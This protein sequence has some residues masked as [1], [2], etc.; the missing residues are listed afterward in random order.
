MGQPKVSVIVP[1]YNVEPYLREC[2]DSIVNQSLNEIE[3]I[4]VNDG[5]KDN[6]LAIMQEYAN[7][8]S[9]VKIISKDN[10]GYGH[11]MNVGLDAATGK[12]IGIVEPDDY[13]KLDMYE[14]L[15]NLA[16]KQQVDLI[17]ADAA[18][19]EDKNGKRIY[20]DY[21]LASSPGQ[22]K[23]Y[24]KVLK[25]NDNI[26]VYKLIMNTWMGIYNRDFL[27]KHNIRHNETP[28][29]SFQDNGFWFQTFAWAE[30]VYFLDK[31][32]YMKRRDNPNSSVHDPNKVFCM[33]E[34][35]K[36]IKAFLDNNSHLKDDLKYMYEYKKFHNFL[37]SYKRI[38][39]EHKIVFLKNMSHEFSDDIVEGLVDDKLFSQ[40]DMEVMY[41]I[42]NDPVAYFFERENTVS[43]S[44]N[45]TKETS[46]NQNGNVEQIKRE[47]NDVKKQLNDMKN[48][49]SFKIGR[50][51]TYV[52]RE[53]RHVYR[54][55]QDNGFRYT[56]DKIVST[57]AGTGRKKESAAEP[58]KKT[59]PVCNTLSKPVTAKKK[60]IKDYDYYKNLTEDQYPK[61]L[62]EWYHNK[63]GKYLNL[64]NP[65][66]FNE[67]IQWLK[68][69]DSTPLKTRLA[70][71]YLVRDWVKEK[72]GEEYLIPLLGVYEKFDDI[73]FRDLPNQFVI[74]TN[75]GSGWNMVVK[76]KEDLNY[77][78]TKM[79]FDTWMSK[80]FAFEYGLELHYKNIQ[81][82]IVI[83]KYI[84]E[85]DSD[86]LDYRFFCFN[87]VP[88]YVW[89]DS[90]SGTQDHKR[91][92][93]NMNWEQQNY[94]V[95][96]PLIDTPITKPETFEKMVELAESLSENFCFVRIDFYSVKGKIFFGEMTF[97]PQSGT[98][99]W[100]DERINLAY[101]EL[102]HLPM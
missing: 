68:L 42:I 50:I 82:K 58:V 100:E 61:E 19:F 102:I 29:A 96:Y 47:L 59:E 11:T 10:S 48:S 89:V 77:E 69:Y 36:F 54:C 25:P 67:K 101:G 32:F 85:L 40:K 78:N 8:D 97:T 20:T 39:I 57:I 87:G 7:N 84:D 38:G 27:N 4:C 91:N 53:V 66:T 60:I 92:I 23:Y 18:Q 63:T 12:Y 79:L 71:K 2:L 90:G 14:T 51:I 80:N 21:K 55:Y 17:K 28:G 70:D 75:H 88:G 30:K 83:E 16:E 56:V 3:I 64:N 6:S 1:I 76:S 72:I 26:D 31:T 98:G 33:S 37:F 5:S 65:K 22:R 45:T 13:I 94:K 93:Y 49:K 15:Y 62:A 24:N 86:I 74:K 46:N 95:N 73:D 81:P 52:P 35:Y 99:K 41:K 43:C 34:E 44:V 9:R